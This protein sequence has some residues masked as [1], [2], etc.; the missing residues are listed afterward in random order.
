MFAGAPVVNDDGS[1]RGA[2]LLCRPL[3]EVSVA[4]QGLIRLMSIAFQGFSGMIH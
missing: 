2:L 4:S 1:I 3:R